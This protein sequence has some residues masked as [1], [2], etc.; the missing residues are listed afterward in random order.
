MV[1]IYWKLAKNS[2]PLFAHLI[3]IRN[4]IYLSLISK[5]VIAGECA[6][7]CAST[8]SQVLE[9]ANDAK[10]VLKQFNFSMDLDLNK[11]NAFQILV[12]NLKIPIESYDSNCTSNKSV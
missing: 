7:R 5:Y 10:T 11:L 1:L 4:T 3:Y 2:K 9:Y 12:D 8:Q 6:K